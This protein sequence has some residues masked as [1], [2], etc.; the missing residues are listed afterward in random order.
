MLLID[1]LKSM[2]NYMHAFLDK[3]QISGFSLDCDVAIF[4][5]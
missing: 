5:T 1:V 3:V 2:R 4:S